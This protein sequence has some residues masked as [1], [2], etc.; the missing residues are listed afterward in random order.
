[1]RTFDY[2]KLPQ[3]LLGGEVGSAVGRIHEHKGRLEAL[4]AMY[5]E[6]LAALRAGAHYDNVDA[7]THIE[8]IYVG[9]DRTAALLDGADPADESEAQVVGYSRALDLLERDCGGLDLS[10]SSIL[11]LYE[12]LYGH[13]SLGKKS[14]YR[15][16]DY[17]FVQT[18]D[19]AKAMPVSPIT[20]FETPLVLGGAC[21]S[22]AD[23]FD[24]RTPSPLV[25]AAVFTVDFLCIRPF[26]EGNGRI[27]RL[28]AD[29]VI[30]KA[31]FDVSRY[32]S[33]DRIVEGSAME[34]YDAL[35]ACTDGWDHARND[36]AP[37]VLYWLKVLDEAYMKAFESIGP[38]TQ[39]PAGKSERVASFVR[40]AA[41]PVTKQQIKDALP[42]VSEATVEAAL[43]RM[44][45]DGAIEKLGAGRATAYRWRR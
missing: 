37:Y 42:S 36:Y 25:L 5:P 13:R 19:G 40:S 7:S 4:G 29:L 26:D 32:V 24:A 17:M 10:T 43:G 11:R 6:E 20:A 38:H 44:V 18:A 45:K 31:G 35:N 22:L 30:S 34:Y 21:D 9:D 39:K 28:F 41:G 23:A 3:E 2:T 33:V 14:R 8:G 27:S 1:M 12:T 16:K 15:K